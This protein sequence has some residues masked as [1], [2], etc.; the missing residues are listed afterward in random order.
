[1]RH[2]H[3]G[4]GRRCLARV[5]CGRRDHV[6][7]IVLK[8]ERPGATHTPAGCV[9]AGRALS[10]RSYE[11]PTY[12]YICQ[13]CG[14][15]FD[16]QATMADY[17]KGLKPTCPHCRSKKAIRSFTNI[18]VISG[19][20]NRAGQDQGEARPERRLSASPAREPEIIAGLA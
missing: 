6:K 8:R 13:D 11:M 9:R 20:R 15:P 10:E 18:N 14:R 12:D 5:K 16:V 19:L 2:A 4:R 17:A 1:M 7:R 3:G